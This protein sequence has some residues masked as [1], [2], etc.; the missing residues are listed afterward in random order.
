MRTFLKKWQKLLAKRLTQ[1]DKQLAADSH[2]LRVKELVQLRNDQV[3]IPHGR[4]CRSSACGCA[5]RGSDGSSD[6]KKRSGSA[7]ALPLP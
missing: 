6:N 7:A 3:T 5:D 2:E 4:P 1:K